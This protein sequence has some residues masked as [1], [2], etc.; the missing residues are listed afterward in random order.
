MYFFFPQMYS[1]FLYFFD[2]FEIYHLYAPVHDCCTV[3]DFCDFFDIK[4]IV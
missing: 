3:S 2:N 1:S 4:F